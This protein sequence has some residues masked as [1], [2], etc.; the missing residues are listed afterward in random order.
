M[1]NIMFNLGAYVQLN[2]IFGEY[3]V[4]VR[5]ENRKVMQIINNVIKAAIV[6]LFAK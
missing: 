4:C 3:G 1:V 6:R 5:M 2:F